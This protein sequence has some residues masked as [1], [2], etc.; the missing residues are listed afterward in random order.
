MCLC[1]CVCVCL[2]VYVSVSVAL[3][4]QHALCMRRI[5]ICDLSG[6]NI[7]SHTIL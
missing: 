4:T 5:V 7:F 2:C 3:I 1:V 6:S